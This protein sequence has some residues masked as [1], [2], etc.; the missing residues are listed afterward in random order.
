[1]KLCRDLERRKIVG[2]AR[3]PRCELAFR[4]FDAAQEVVKVRHRRCPFRR[5]GRTIQSL[6]P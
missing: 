2:A 4:L 6:E 3:R 1:M 5:R